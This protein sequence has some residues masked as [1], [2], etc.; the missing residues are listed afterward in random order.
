M[1]AMF[2]EMKMFYFHRNRGL[3]KNVGQKN[4]DLKKLA[5][6][7]PK[8]LTKM[9]VELVEGS[10]YSLWENSKNVVMKQLIKKISCFR[11]HYLMLFQ[12]WQL[13]LSAL[14]AFKIFIVT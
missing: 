11:V 3:L 12:P 14:L 5:R 8:P 4:V 2:A 9:E 7:K 6:K 10:I 13:D 1:G